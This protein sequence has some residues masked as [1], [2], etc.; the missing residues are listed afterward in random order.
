MQNYTH[1][2]EHPGFY[3]PQAGEDMVEDADG[4]FWN[5]PRPARKAA[6]SV[7]KKRLEKEKQER[8]EERKASERHIMEMHATYAQREADRR[9][10]ELSLRESNARQEV[11]TFVADDGLQQDRFDH[12]GERRIRELTAQLEAE[13]RLRAGIS[14][15]FNGKTKLHEQP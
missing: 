4:F 3:Q 15:Q 5:V 10:V 1:K 6:T 14:H 7:F 2:G 12:D 9:A 11:S 13:Q 8:A